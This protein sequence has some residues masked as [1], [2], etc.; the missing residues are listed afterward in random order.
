MTYSE[1]VSRIVSEMDGR[2]LEESEKKNLSAI[3]SALASS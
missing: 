2:A 1:V 3:R